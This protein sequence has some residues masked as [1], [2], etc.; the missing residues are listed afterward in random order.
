M[1]KRTAKP[2]PGQFPFEQIEG[3]TGASDAISGGGAGAGIPDADTVERTAGRAARG[4]VKRDKRK[5]F[6]EAGRKT[7][8]GGRR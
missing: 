7:R 2:R 3:A 4:D 5:I 1:A 8:R 6:P